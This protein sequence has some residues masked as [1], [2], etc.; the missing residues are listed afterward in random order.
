MGQLIGGEPSGE[1]VHSMN[2]ANID[3]S[4]DYRRSRCDGPETDASVPPAVLNESL[5]RDAEV[6]ISMGLSTSLSKG[7]LTSIGDEGGRGTYVPGLR[8][9][10][11]LFFAVIYLSPGDYHRFHSPSAWVVE[12]RR[13]FIGR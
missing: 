7:L 4:D 9:G 11:S 10:N 3:T 8:P 2:Q 1:E 12:R 5:S 6:A 13:H